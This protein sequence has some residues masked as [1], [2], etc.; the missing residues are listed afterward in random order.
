IWRLRSEPASQTPDSA[1]SSHLEELVDR[2]KS[3][4]M[5]GR[6]M[7]YPYTIT[8]KFLSFPYKYYYKNV[9]AFRYYVFSVVLC[10]P[11]FYKIQKLACSPANV[12][13]FAEKAAKEKAAGGH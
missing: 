12:A 7:K 11:I 2:F 9:W 8:A 4:K 10:M 1:S 3:N 5:S 13:K 6:T